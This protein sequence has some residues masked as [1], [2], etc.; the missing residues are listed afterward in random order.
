MRLF[1]K[2]NSIPNYLARLTLLKIGKLHIRLH[3]ITA[4]DATPYLHNHPFWYLSFVL[5][6]GYT[7]QSLTARSNRLHVASHQS[8]TIIF[9][10]PAKLH[11]I[12][13][14]TYARTLFITWGSSTPWTLQRHP[15]I[16]PPP[17]FRQPPREGLYQR[18]IN[19]KALWCKFATYW[20]IGNSCPTKANESTKYSVHQVAVWS[21]TYFTALPD[22]S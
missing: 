17:D 7:E 1:R 11:R 4:A 18:T 21:P 16:P 6:G 13:T 2:Y 19:G 15:D 9:G 8:P 20:Y 5:K 10:S 22:E 3:T 12:E 14:C